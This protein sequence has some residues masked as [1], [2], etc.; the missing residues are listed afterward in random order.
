MQ[1][2]VTEVRSMGSSL[3]NDQQELELI[4]LENEDNPQQEVNPTFDTRDRR[5]RPT[6]ATGERPIAPMLPAFVRELNKDVQHLISGSR[7]RAAFGVRTPM[8]SATFLDTSGEQRDMFLPG[9]VVPSEEYFTNRR[10]SHPL[11]SRPQLTVPGLRTN[12]QK[13]LDDWVKRQ[14]LA[15]H[16]SD[17]ELDSDFE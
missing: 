15:E 2:E 6:A 10:K 17:S 9:E 4:D 14:K 5:I 1:T 13:V 11:F 16:A 3:N 7:P 12:D 8:T